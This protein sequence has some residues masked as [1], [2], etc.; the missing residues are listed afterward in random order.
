MLELKVG[1][2]TLL[3]SRDFSLTTALTKFSP[4]QNL[5][6]PQPGQRIIVVGS[7]GSGKTTLAETIAQRLGLVHVE[8]DALHWDPDWREAD[9][10]VFRER[11]SEALAG[12]AWVVDGNY[13]KVRDIIWPRADTLIWLELPLAV[14][15]WRLFWRTVRRVVTREE[16]WNGN[17]ETFRGA[18]FSKDSLLVYVFKSRKKHRQ[19]YP[20]L[21]RQPEY[22]HLRL[23]H[24]RTAAQVESWLDTLIAR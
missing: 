5:N 3:I 9:L 14:V 23:I 12:S 1:A 22:S 24:F 11:L 6:F 20:D 2:S 10:W 4:E 19:T 17:K 13:A 16:L 7:T 18:F 21:F 15:L 8:I